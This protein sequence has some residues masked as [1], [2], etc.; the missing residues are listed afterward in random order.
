MLD[1]L[2][3]PS[4][5]SGYNSMNIHLICFVQDNCE[6]FLMGNLVVVDEKDHQR[7]TRQANHQ[8]SGT[9]VSNPSI[10]MDIQTDYIFWMIVYFVVSGL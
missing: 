5:C 8:N 7:K 4:S 6:K 10:V 1:A 3:A 2:I 9:T